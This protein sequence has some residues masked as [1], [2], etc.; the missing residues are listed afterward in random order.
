MSAKV[1]VF[2]KVLGK[3]NVFTFRM[4]FSQKTKK[5]S[6]RFESDNFR[7][8]PNQESYP[9]YP[10]H[11]CGMDMFIFLKGQSHKIVVNEMTAL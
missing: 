2:V 10:H 6:R 3:V 11:K 8:N 5:I 7:F 1:F 9:E 4:L